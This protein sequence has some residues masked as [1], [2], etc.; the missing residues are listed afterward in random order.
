MSTRSNIAILNKDTK[1]ITKIYCHWDGYPEYVGEILNTN[2]KDEKKIRKL[3]AL[4]SISSLMEEVEPNPNE[5]HSFNEPQP[6]VTIAY[7]R[8]RGEDWKWNKPEELD[9]N[10][11]RKFL[12]NPFDIEYVYLYI[13]S[14]VGW[15][16]WKTYGLTKKS[17]EKIKSEMKYLDKYLK[18][19]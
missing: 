19:V 16:F 8:D 12:R 17:D 18:E 7:T 13:D 4:G 10:K 15:V 3:I 14:K 5:I 1:T 11:F 6:M 9:F 2:Y